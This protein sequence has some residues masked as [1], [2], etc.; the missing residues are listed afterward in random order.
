LSW[1]LRLFWYFAARYIKGQAVLR[2]KRKGLIAYINALQGVRRVLLAALLGFFVLQT[3][4]FAGIGALV[5][6]VLLLNLDPRTTLIVLCS[7]FTAAFLIPVIALAI[8]FSERFWYKMSGAEK[9]VE[10]LYPQS[11]SNAA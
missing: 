11:D 5:T 4:V 9:M 2:A 6:G 1:I 10:E 7:V 8:L 3:I